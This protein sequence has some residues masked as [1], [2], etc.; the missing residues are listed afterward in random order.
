MK[1]KL[2]LDGDLVTFAAS[3]SSYAL[4]CLSNVS[5]LYY[6]YDFSHFYVCLYIA[7]HLNVLY[8]FYLSFY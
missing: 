7:T 2:R 6:P 8:I 5:F 3:A 1:V 4:S